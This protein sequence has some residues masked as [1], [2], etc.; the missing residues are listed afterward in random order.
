MGDSS[1]LLQCH[2]IRAWLEET[3]V[4]FEP[5]ETRRGYLFYTRKNIRNQRAEGSSA[6]STSGGAVTEIDPDAPTR[7]KRSL[8]VEDGEYEDSLLR[9]LY[10]FV[11]R[12]R[13]DDALNLC[14]ESDEPWRAASMRGGLFW[15][16]PRLEVEDKIGD[17]DMQPRDTAGNVNRALWKQTCAALAQDEDNKL[18]DRALYAALSGRLDEVLLVSKSWEDIVWAY[19]NAMIE[20]RVD[21]D[22]VRENSLYIPAETMS[23]GHIQSKYPPVEG[24]KQ[25]FEAMR[26]HESDAVKKETETPF[27]RLQTAIILDGFAEYIADFA[28]KLRSD[29]LSEDEGDLLRFVVHAALYMRQVGF[30][31]PS[32]AV[33][34]V[35]EEYIDQLS[36]DKH[37]ELVALYTSQLPAEKQ[38]EVYAE[39]LQKVNDPLPVRFQLLQLAEK[40]RLDW[41]AIAKRA[42]YLA[43]LQHDVSDSDG[44]GQLFELAEPVEPITPQELE[45]VRAIEWV[46]S[47]PRLYD[48][49]LTQVCKLARRFMLRGR[50]NAAARLFNSL[51]SG[52]VQQE[53]IDKSDVMDSPTKASQASAQGGEAD[54]SSETASCF[55]EYIHILAMCDSLAFYSGWAELMCQQPMV[56]KDRSR[57]A[58]HVQAQ[59]IEWRDEVVPKTAEAARMFQ[60]KILGVGWL[61][62]PS[63]QVDV[64]ATGRQD[65][66]QQMRAAELALLRALYVPEVVFRLH[67]VLYDSRVA[68][69]ENLERSLELAQVVAEEGEGIYR[70]MARASAAYPKGRLAAFMGLMRKSAFEMLRS[71]QESQEAMPVL[72]GEPAGL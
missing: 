66:Q 38:T 62:E 32:D 47:D 15:R 48:Y 1:M 71:K 34:T 31:L 6:G 22:V 20:E 49:A 12:G 35:L 27:H 59:W 24:L 14:V 9:S 28:Q 60:D 53:W 25:V 42:S 72:L 11:R 19:V 52:F 16:D 10:E 3:A 70:E 67:A 50:T 26:S 61:T 30:D 36:L 46:T 40:H 56:P 33:E 43:L 29:A 54:T 63:L 21:K 65:V 7:Q 18:Y 55:L 44:A 45:Q 4:P 8:A 13:L 57:A 69:P 17:G 41:H 51:P 2:A 64:S 5:V 68:V 58:A 37:H 39:F 23:L